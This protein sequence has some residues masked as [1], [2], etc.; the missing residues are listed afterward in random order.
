VATLCAWES[1]ETDGRTNELSVGVLED[2]GFDSYNFLRPADLREESLSSSGLLYE[3]CR[4]YA[5]IDNCESELKM[6]L[7]ASTSMMFLFETH[8]LIHHHCF[9]WA[10]SGTLHLYSGP[11]WELGSSCEGS[12]KWKACSLT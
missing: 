1:A 11:E 2:P 6:P 8:T 9:V 5:H 10:P 12:A 7:K 3:D 4:S